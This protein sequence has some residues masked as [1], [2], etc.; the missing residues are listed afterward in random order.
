MTTF[1]IRQCTDPACRLRIPLDPELFS[2]AYCP[3][4]GAPM[5]VAVEAYQN[6]DCSEQMAASKIR[7]SG[8]LDNIRSVHN[9]GAIFRTG[10]GA[11]CNISIWAAL[12]R[13]RMKT[14]LSPRRRLAQRRTWPGRITETVWTWR[15]GSKMKV[16]SFLRWNARPGRPRSIALGRNRQTP[17]NGC[18]WWVMKKRGWT[19]V[20]WQ[21][22]TGCSACP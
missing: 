16:I 17:A 19:R 10:D 15:T 8:L 6:V 4:C 20:C 7:L 22:V 5:T 3:R 1:E 18:W 2:G 14:R 11:G 13:P 9:V 12:R 21:S